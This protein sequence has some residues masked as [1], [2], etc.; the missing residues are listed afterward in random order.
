M[1]DKIH[2]MINAVKY[3]Q[4]KNLYQGDLEAD[5]V[6]ELENHSIVSQ[7]IE[8]YE[9]Y[10]TDIRA[11]LPAEDEMVEICD[12]LR[13]ALD[14]KKADMKEQI[15]KVLKMLEDKGMELFNRSECARDLLK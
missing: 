4:Y 13:D 9:C 5:I 14:M 10:K 1:S 3:P 15:E 2:R 7:K 12:H 8:D 6:H 11:V